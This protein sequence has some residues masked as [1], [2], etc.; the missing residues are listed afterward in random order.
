[1]KNFFRNRLIFIICLIFL[2]GCGYI[3]RKPLQAELAI[4][5]GA[6]LGTSYGIALATA[7][8]PPDPEH[9]TVLQKSILF[10]GST[11]KKISDES[12]LRACN[13]PENILFGFGDE[14]HTQLSIPDSYL[15]DPYHMYHKV[16][17]PAE[18]ISLRMRK[19]DLGS[20]C[21]N[22]TLG[23]DHG[24]LI[25]VKINRH[26]KNSFTNLLT[27]EQRFYPVYVGDLDD[28]YSLFK[29]KVGMHGELFVPKNDDI[30]KAVFLIC[31]HPVTM[32]ISEILTSCKVTAEVTD[33]IYIE[34]LIENVS[35][36][37]VSKAN[38]KILTLIRSFLAK[39]TK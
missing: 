24:K 7:N 37:D 14:N 21:S 25:T 4:V 27:I 19:D 16:K 8:P 17:D 9:Y 38:E 30:K 1:M 10:L 29:M 11:A 3:F 18:F 26:L 20:A 2:A 5:N 15:F 35:V 13:S 31:N 28:Q 12:E 39:P 6:I 34:Y 32:T 33:T 22:K 23:L 36:E